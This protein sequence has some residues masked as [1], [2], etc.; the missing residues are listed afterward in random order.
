MWLGGEDGGAEWDEPSMPSQVLP[1]PAG[2]NPPACRCAGQ[3]AAVKGGPG[4]AL[5]A[6]RMSLL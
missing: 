5:S 4:V 6:G 1:Y 3:R 2:C